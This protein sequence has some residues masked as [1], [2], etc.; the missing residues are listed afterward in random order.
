MEDI[1]KLLSFIPNIDG[2]NSNR[3][4]MY[5]SNRSGMQ[6]F[7]TLQGMPAV[8]AVAINTSTTDLLR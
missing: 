2:V 7:L 8:K 3:V 6:A 4:G 1:V 5:G